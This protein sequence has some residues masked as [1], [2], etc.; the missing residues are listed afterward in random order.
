MENLQTMLQ[1]FR[2]MKMNMGDTKL[3]VCGS[4][5]VEMRNGEMGV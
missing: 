4:V 1:R 5:E 3:E 2:S